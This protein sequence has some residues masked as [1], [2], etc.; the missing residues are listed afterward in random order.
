LFKLNIIYWIWS[1]TSEWQITSYFYPS[2]PRQTEDYWC[3]PYL[4]TVTDCKIISHWQSFVQNLNDILLKIALYALFTDNSSVHNLDYIL[5]TLASSVHNL[6]D[7]LLTA[8][9][10]TIVTDSCWSV[11][12]VYKSNVNNIQIK[13]CTEFLLAKCVQSFCL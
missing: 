7:I 2:S 3:T 13:F 12:M 1:W 5:L 9:L 11:N 8:A 6:N 10:Y 4:L